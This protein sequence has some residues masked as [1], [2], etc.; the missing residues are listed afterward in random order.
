[1]HGSSTAS[2]MVEVVN[3]LLNTNHALAFDMPLSMKPEDALKKIEEIIKEK[4]EGKGALLLVDMGSL[5]YFDKMISNNTGIEVESV[6]MVTTLMAI[7]ATRMALMNASL[8]DIVSSLKAEEKQISE[9]E[10][11]F[12]SKINQ[13]SFQ[14]VQQVKELHKR[15]KS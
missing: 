12:S 2:S 10:N 7:K 6:D 4:N 3:H 14:L 13:L 5:R 15:L 11:S 9:A 8:S 1:M